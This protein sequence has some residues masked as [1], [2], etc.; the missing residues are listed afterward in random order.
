MVAMPF[1]PGASTQL[2][3]HSRYLYFNSFT[4]VKQV[5]NEAEIFI[6]DT[7]AFIDGYVDPFATLFSMM[8]LMPDG[9]IYMTITNSVLC[10]PY[11]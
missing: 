11:H 9:K 7:V 5:D 1:Y 4:V 2:Y 8:S 10:L 6:S 3:P